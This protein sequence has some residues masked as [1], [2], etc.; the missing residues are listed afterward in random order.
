[1]RSGDAQVMR[2]K[3]YP[4]ALDGFL[5]LLVAEL[6]ERVVVVALALRQE[7]VQVAALVL[8]GRNHVSHT[9]L[10]NNNATN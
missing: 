9:F 7:R 3:A 5:R 1:M 10:T 8:Q 2:Q 4:R 6:L